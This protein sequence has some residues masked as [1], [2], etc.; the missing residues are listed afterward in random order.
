[1]PALRRSVFVSCVALAAI[2]LSLYAQNP[3]LPLKPSSVRFAV[4]GDMGT[5][6]EAAI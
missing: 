2:C 4:I 3:A 6:R 5:G 1:M